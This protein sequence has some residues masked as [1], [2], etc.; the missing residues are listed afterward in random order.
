MFLF[1]GYLFKC[2]TFSGIR[3][4]DS[5]YLFRSFSL[6][7]PGILSGFE[8]VSGEVSHLKDRSNT[9]GWVLKGEVSVA[10]QHWISFCIGTRPCRF[11]GTPDIRNGDRI[12][13]VGEGGETLNVI[14]LQNETTGFISTNDQETKILIPIAIAGCVLIAVLGILGVLA[15]ALSLTGTHNIIGISS[16]FLIWG[17]LWFGIAWSCYIP[18]HKSNLA[19]RNLSNQGF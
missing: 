8:R 16:F 6:S 17:S 13:V 3:P 11:T 19:I 1:W 4:H 10:T 15:V 7:L 5:K 9:S 14:A 18:L 12:T 2:G